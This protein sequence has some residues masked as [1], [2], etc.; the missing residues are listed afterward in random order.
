MSGGVDSAVAALL[1]ARGGGRGG[2]RDARAVVGPRERRR[3]QLLLGA[4]RARR[5]RRWRTA[6]ACPTSRSTCARSSAPASSTTGSRPRRRPDAEPVRALQ[7]QRASRRD[8]RARRPPRRQRRSPPATTR[9]SSDGPLLRT[10]R[11]RAQG[12]ELRALRARAR[13]A[14][15]RCASRS[16][17]CA[18]RRCASSPGEAGLAVAGRR[19]SQDLCFLAGTRQGAFLERHGGLGAAA[20]PDRR[21]RTAACSASTPARTCFTVGQRHGLG[22]GGTR[23]AVRARAPTRSANTVTVGPRSDLLARRRGGARGDAPPRRRAAWTACACARTAARFACRLRGRPAAGRHERV[24]VEL[25][26]PAERT[27]PGQLACL[28]AG[29]AGR[30]PRHRSLRS[31][32][33]CRA[34][35]L[36]SSRDDL[37]R[38]PRALP[39]LLRGARAQAHPLGLAG[40][41]RA[42]P[43]GAAHRRRACTR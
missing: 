42:R 17:R 41:L 23:A 36:R 40:A 11:R 28:Y 10:R 32:R 30:R 33:A 8:A 2:R 43:L 29:D 5:A 4:G 9:A 38:D 20:G 13:V 35:S 26:E 15:A 22:I 19:D 27:A 18:S 3:S 12:P 25:A 37:R 34:R 7:R 1:V 16:A 6:W 39:E 24:R 31:P 21:S 14:R